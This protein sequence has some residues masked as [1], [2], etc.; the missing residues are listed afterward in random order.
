MIL[1]AAHAAARQAI[2]CAGMAPMFD[3]PDVATRRRAQ[4]LVDGFCRRCTIR[5][6]C[7]AAAR[8]Q[9]GDRST[10]ESYTGI[11]GGVA[12]VKG[13]VIARLTERKVA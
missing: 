3:L 13:R 12:F 11:A 5:Q 7:A 2:P 1:G 9:P 10:G 4:A 6:E 8:Q